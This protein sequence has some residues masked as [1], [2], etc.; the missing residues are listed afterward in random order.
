VKEG[1]KMRGKRLVG[2]VALFLLVALSAWGQEEVRID[3]P[4]FK[5]VERLLD[6]VKV[7]WKVD[8]R[9]FG[10]RPI[11]AWVKISFFDAEGFKLD[12]DVTK[13]TIKPY[14]I[15]TVSDTTL[16]PISVFRRVSRAEVTLDF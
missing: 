9:N 6:S 11:A 14:G 8:I 5:V 16:M 2:L 15:T 13:A 4:K 10:D 12:Q 3:A 7:S 1:R